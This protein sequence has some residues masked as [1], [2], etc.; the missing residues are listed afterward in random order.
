MKMAM[1]TKTSQAY[2]TSDLA[3]AT[4]LYCSGTKLLNIERN[5]GWRATF[6][7]ESPKPELISKFQEGTATCLALAYYNAYQSLKQKLFGGER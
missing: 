5:N 2:R 6:V 4:Y 3:L 1:E 7:F